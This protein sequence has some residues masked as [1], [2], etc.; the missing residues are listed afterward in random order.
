MAIT[1]EEQIG[2]HKG[3]ISVLVQEQ[4]EMLKLAN[5]TQQLIQYHVEELK[6]LGID[7]IADMK[8]AQ[9]EYQKKQQTKPK[10]ALS[11]RLA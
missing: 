3:S 7:F 4:Q 10:D 5:L 11:D 2:I 6:K 8:K 9:E 1:K